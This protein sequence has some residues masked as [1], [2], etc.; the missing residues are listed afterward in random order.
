M[1]AHNENVSAFAIYLHSAF[2]SVFIWFGN[3]LLNSKHFNIPLIKV[4]IKCGVRE[5]HTSIAIHLV[6]MKRLP[7][8][9]IY[10][11]IENVKSHHIAVIFPWITNSFEV[12]I[13]FAHAKLNSILY[14]W[15]MIQRWLKMLTRLQIF[16]CCTC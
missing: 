3:R 2:S 15:M 4:F 11:I 12:S 7:V 8:K 13:P 14:I 10:I 16:N 6:L 9:V 1:N 5:Q